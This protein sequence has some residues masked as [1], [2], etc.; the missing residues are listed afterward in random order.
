MQACVYARFL[1]EKA[2]VKFVLGDPQGKLSNVVIDE[3][4]AQKRVKGIKTDDGLTHFGDLVIIA[5][6][7]PC[8]YI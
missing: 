1:C 8:S 7:N 3:N 4:G 5:G 6:Q 2:G